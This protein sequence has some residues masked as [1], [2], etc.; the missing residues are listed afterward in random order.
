MQLFNELSNTKPVKIAPFG[1]DIEKINNHKD[2]NKKNSQ[3][4]NYIGALDWIPNQEGLLWFIQ[5]CFDKIIKTFPNIKLNIAGRNAPTWFVQKLNHPN[6]NYIGEVK[7]AYE[8][9]QNSGPVIVPLFSGS[10]MRVKIIESMALRKSIVAT[11]IAAE[12]INCENNTNIIIAN[13]VKEYTN[14]VIELLSNP[15]LQNKIGENAYK[16]VKDQYDFIKIASDI[17][18]FIK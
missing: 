5:N 8:F 10:G 2:E 11:D 4:I 13:N 3:S 1:I 15:D 17:L 9:L 7:N 6:I 18:N 14:A 12:G 16:F